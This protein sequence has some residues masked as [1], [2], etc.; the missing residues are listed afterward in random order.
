MRKRSQAYATHDGGM[1]FEKITCHRPKAFAGA[2]V[3]F[4]R[5]SVDPTADLRC[6]LREWP[7][8][9]LRGSTYFLAHAAFPPLRAHAAQNTDSHFGLEAAVSCAEH[10]GPLWADSDRCCAMHISTL[11]ADSRH[12]LRVRDA[13]VYFDKAD[14]GVGRST[15]TALAI[16]PRMHP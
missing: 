3:Y 6:G 1:L 8:L 9:P 11:R 14:V 4:V 5:N 10:E 2:E 7:V 12:S 15:F 13:I 16:L